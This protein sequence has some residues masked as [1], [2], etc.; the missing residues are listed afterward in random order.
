M[1]VKIHPDPETFLRASGTFISHDPLSPGVVA[2]VAERIAAGVQPGPED[3]IFVFVEEEGVVVG[4]AMHTPP[5]PLF[6]SRMP[7]AAAEELARVLARRGLRLPGVSGAE[8]STSVSAR[9]WLQLTG[10]RSRLV[11]ALRLYR[12]QSL[13]APE[14]ASGQPA[15]ARAPQDTDLVSRWMR[16][17]HDEATP[18][19][20]AQDW[21]LVAS[22]RISAGEVR[23]WWDGGRPVAM[24][25][26]SQTA[27]A[28]AR[29]GPVYTPPEF[30]RGGFGTAVT[31]AATKAAL[32]AGSREVILYTDL[33]NPTSNS[34]Y[35]ALGFRPD[36]DAQELYFA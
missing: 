36:H 10:R 35:V 30:R 9:A 24:A 1:R 12:L 16:E 4:V 18:R 19:A 33:A 20:P 14:G 28:V 25:C 15:G 32:L 13:L 22:R 26:S 2:D 29:V 5:H 8:D 7:A 27:A 11:A 17:F 23:V 3:D 34:I 31:V 21:R 6:L